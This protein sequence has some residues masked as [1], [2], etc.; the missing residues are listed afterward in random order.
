MNS[1]P[2]YVLGLVAQDMRALPRIFRAAF[3]HPWVDTYQIGFGPPLVGSSTVLSQRAKECTSAIEKLELYLEHCIIDAE[4]CQRLAELQ[5]RLVVRRFGPVEAE[6][7]REASRQALDLRIRLKS[8]RVA[9]KE[10][11]S[12]MTS[13]QLDTEQIASSSIEAFAAHFLIRLDDPRNTR[14]FDL[15]ELNL[16]PAFQNEDT[17]V[18]ELRTRPE[19]RDY[20][21]AFLKVLAEVA[22]FEM[23]RI[24]DPRA[25]AKVS[26]DGKNL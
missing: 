24:G 15:P 26:R 6:S 5:R 23:A 2:V 8:P 13:M 18:V 3:S 22:P 19:C 1:E 17:C 11:L 14:L 12:S 25:W 4:E 21:A 7:L 20:W 10:I 16:D 9:S